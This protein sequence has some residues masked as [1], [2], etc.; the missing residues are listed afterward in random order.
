MKTI[1]PFGRQPFRF[2]YV[3]VERGEVAVMGTVAGV[4]SGLVFERRDLAVAAGL[5]AV[6]IAA[7][8]SRKRRH[9]RSGR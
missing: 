3:E 1:S 7:V 9:L 5:L 2:G 6:G 4:P 8:G